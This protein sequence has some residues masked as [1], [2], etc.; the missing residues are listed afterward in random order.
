[1]WFG[2]WLRLW[3]QLIDRKSGLTLAESELMVF[4]LDIEEVRGLQEACSRE[5][6]LVGARLGVSVLRL[7]YTHGRVA[8]LLRFGLPL[9]SGTL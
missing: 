2:L 3:D 4:I 7:L 9:H 5:E 6:W 8:T 1:M